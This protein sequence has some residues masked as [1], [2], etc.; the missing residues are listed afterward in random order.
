M[1]KYILYLLLSLFILTACN[2]KRERIEE[3]AYNPYD[4]SEET[5][6]QD[7]KSDTIYATD[8]VAVNLRLY[9]PGTQKSN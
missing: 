8:S 1:K 7:A 5:E 3:G 9:E 4:T 2:I 6:A